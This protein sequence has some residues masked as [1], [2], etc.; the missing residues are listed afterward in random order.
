[1]TSKQ[2]AI[3]ET[4][5]KTPTPRAAIIGAGVA[6]IVCANALQRSGFT[7]T[8]LEKSRGLG[9]RLAKRLRDNGVTFDHGAQY[10]TVRSQEFRRIVEQPVKQGCVDCW[11]P[12]RQETEPT[13]VV[14]WLIGVPTINALVKPLADGLDISLNREVANLW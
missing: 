9:G 4:A 13:G 3:V 1:L 7:A 8:I 6:G 2:E 11:R 12:K 5:N 14:D 10:F